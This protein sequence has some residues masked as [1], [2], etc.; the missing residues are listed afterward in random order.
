MSLT[1][2]SKHQEAL[3]QVLE[4]KT[5][6]KFLDLTRLER[7]LTHASARNRDGS[8]YERLEFLGD[9]VLG[10]VVAEMLFAL[11]PNA[12]EG[13]LSIRL[14]SL[15]DA[16]TC[17]EV[18]DDLD[19]HLL[20]RKGSDMGQIESRRLSN[21]RADVVESIIATIYLDG[22]LDAARPFIE[23]HWGPHARHL[24]AGRR[25]PK[26]ELQEWAHRVGGI[27]PVYTVIDRSG[28]DH[29]PIF[30]VELAVNGYKPE[31]ADGQSKRLAERAAAEQMLLREGV[32]SEGE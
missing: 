16:E 14:N 5:G 32:W 3:A 6:H 19:L 31:R 23:T 10:L 20:I 17:A 2:L 9:R 21:V 4:E 29:E 18:A 1:S 28:P 8:D 15:V 25:D 22:G 30:S 11:Y 13:E 24:T 7:A 26:T 27:Q 12:D